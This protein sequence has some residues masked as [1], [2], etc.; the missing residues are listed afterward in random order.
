MDVRV[1]LL[2]AGLLAVGGCRGATL[3]VEARTSAR[4]Q[5]VLFV[6]NSLTYFNDLP[7]TLATLVRAD[8]D[9]IIVA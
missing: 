1:A 7:G 8:G 3:P 2:A 9:D 5:R 4:P 6:G